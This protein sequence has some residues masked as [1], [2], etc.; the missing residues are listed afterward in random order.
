[1]KKK[2]RKQAFQFSLGVHEGT[3]N[4]VIIKREK[5][6]CKTMS[7]K[8]IAY[9]V[10]IKI[11]FC[12]LQNFVILFLQKKKTEAGEVGSFSPNAFTGSSW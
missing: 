2:I 5:Q 9:F 3:K 10:T 8:N 6:E 1:M 12:P 11:A 4:K 7:E